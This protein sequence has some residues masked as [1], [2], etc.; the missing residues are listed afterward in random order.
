MF[1]FKL[2]KAAIYRAVLLR[3]IPPF[4][5]SGFFRDIFLLVSFASLSLFI[6]RDRVG[7]EY[8]YFLETSIVLF[9][10][11]LIFFEAGAFFAKYLSVPPLFMTLQEALKKEDV[12]I[13]EFL[14]FPAAC[15]VSK[16]YSMG[17]VD[18][19][20]VLYF[21]IKDSDLDFV[22]TRALIDKREVLRDLSE[23]FKKRGKISDRSFSPCFKKT[24]E[25]ALRIAAK[26]G[27][28]RITKGDILASLCENNNYMR[29]VL[30]RVNMKTTDIID[31]VSWQ[32]EILKEEESFSRKSLAK[33]GSL[34]REWTCGYTVL[35]DNFSVDLTESLRDAGFPKTVGHKKEVESVERVLSRKETNSVVLTGEPG[36]GRKSIIYELARKSFFGECLPEVNYMRIVKLDI[37][38]VIA[39]SE[40]V[41]E[42]EMVI[43]NIFSE[44]TNAGNVILVIEEMHNFVAGEKKPGAV[45][46]S[47][48]LEPYLHHPSFRLIGVTSFLGFRKQVEDNPSLL[49]LMEKVEVSEISKKETLRLLE[50]MIPYLERK[51]KKFIS[52]GAL[53]KII[54]LSDRYMPNDPF[55]EKAMDILEEAAVHVSQKKESFLLPHHVADII[56]EKTEIPVGE[57][58]KEEKET[59]LHLEELMHERIVNQDMAV[60]EVSSSLRRSRTGVTTR[61]GLMGSFLFLG[62]TGVG[63]TETAKAIADIYFKSQ[64]RMIRID[65]SEFQEI[66]D[67]SRLIGS[68][69]QEGVLSSKVRENPFSLILLDE[70]EKSHPDILNIFLQILDEGHLTDGAGRKVDFKSTMIIAT[71]NAGYQIIIDSMEKGEDW[72]ELKKKILGR[73]FQES[74]FRPEFVN[75]FDG[76]VLFEPLSKEHLVS[77]SGMQLERVAEDLKEKDIEFIISEDLK[78]SIVEMS[79]DPLFGAREMQRIVQDKVGNTISSAILREEIKRGDRFT[80][81]MDDF[82]IIKH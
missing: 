5:L 15:A 17:G 73:L 41:E 18:S 75:R 50:M 62:P 37:T 69:R 60:K 34:A 36:T 46:I 12:N 74:V 80:I 22:L 57:I 3:K 8:E 24:M 68:E 7:L 28:E 14:D 1:N 82:S 78:R 55:P 2:K 53:K 38:S 19:Y 31:T 63:K 11:S 16:A 58:D 45:N 32:E 79:Y 48:L 9:A 20:L 67:V 21:I 56:S 23:T 76:V 13:A 49:S 30:Y 4:L 33:K 51:Y 65:M 40:G 52:F 6:F 81:N 29:E 42:T 35:L 61:K 27:K 66:S 47:A 64:K 77:I 25:G 70:I 26:R 72:G 59:L 44:A 43:N 39:S 54:N 10:I 71:S